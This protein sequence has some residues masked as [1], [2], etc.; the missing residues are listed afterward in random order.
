VR[1]VTDEL[2]GP[3]GLAFSPDERF[4]YVGDWDPGHKAVVRYAI[5]AAGRRLGE[6]EV[7]CDLTAEPGEDAI[8]GLKVDRAG[9]LYV[10]GPGGVWVLSPEG[11]RLG[12]LRLPESPHNL[13][14]GDADGR[15]LYVTALTSVYRLRPVGGGGPR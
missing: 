15:A 6:G 7:L 5:D 10:C 14:W 11:E 8:D 2:Q 13:A 1:L 4:L 9:N 12:L 3:N